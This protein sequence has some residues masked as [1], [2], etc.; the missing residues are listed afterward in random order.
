MEIS[1]TRDDVISRLKMTLKHPKATL[2]Y[3]PQ[4][5]RKLRSEPLDPYRNVFEVDFNRISDSK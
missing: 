5:V 2:Y 4:S 3:Q 1:K